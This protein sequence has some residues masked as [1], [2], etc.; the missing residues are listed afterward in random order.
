MAEQNFPDN[1]IYELDNLDVLRGMNSETVDLV[2]T[3][4]PFNTRRDRSGDRRVLRG[5]LALGRHRTALRQPVRNAA[6]TA[7]PPTSARRGNNAGRQWTSSGR[8]E[9]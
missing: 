1:A 2:A 9:K 4:P 5:Q 6:R 7:T 3:G 8:R